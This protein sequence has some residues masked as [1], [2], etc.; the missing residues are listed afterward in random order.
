MIFSGRTTRKA[1]K[2]KTRLW[3]LLATILFSGVPFLSQEPQH[4]HLD[5]AETL[6]SVNFPTSCATTVQATFTRGMA[7]LYSF[8]YEQAEL[9]FENVAQKDPGCAMAYWGQAM[10]VYHQLWERPSKPTLQKGAEFL[11]KAR[12]LKSAPREHDYIRAL[13]VFYSDD[14]PN[15]HDARAEAYCKA[16]KGVADRY[17]EDREAQILYAL[18]VLG[19]SSYHD[20]NLTSDKAAVAIL[21][22]L[23]S[24]PGA[25]AERIEELHDRHMVEA[26][27]AA[28]GEPALAQVL[29]E[30]DHATLLLSA[31]SSSEARASGRKRRM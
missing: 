29:R 24:E 22:K 15:K 3:L 5:A 8:E 19:S 27:A 12:E 14:D 4:H 20:P 17:P 1:L 11:T 7:L 16:M 23:A 31:D 28:V 30:Q 2:L 6:G 10:S 26:A 21:I 25:D 18:S 13:S 9:A